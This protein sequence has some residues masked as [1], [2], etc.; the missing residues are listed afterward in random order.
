MNEITIPKE[1]IISDLTPGEIM[2][3]KLVYDQN[4]QLFK[5]YFSTYEDYIPKVIKS[6]QKKLYLKD[7]GEEFEDLILRDKANKLFKVETIKFEEFWDKYH[8][9]TKLPKTDLQPA[10]KRW[11]ILTVKDKKLAIANINNYFN[12]LTDPMYCKKARTYLTDKNYL[13]EFKSIVN[14]NNNSMSST[15]ML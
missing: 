5:H 6:L 11:N 1:L 4:K 15:T 2:L 9:I 12:S 3:L 14:N 10:K 8:S 7:N 13:D